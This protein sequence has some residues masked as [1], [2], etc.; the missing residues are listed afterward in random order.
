MTDKEPSPLVKMAA[1]G[2][3]TAL[4]KMAEDKGQDVRKPGFMNEVMNQPE[5]QQSGATL[6]SKSISETVNDVTDNAGT[7]VKNG[8]E[9][10]NADNKPTYQMIRENLGSPTD[11]LFRKVVNNII[12]RVIDVGSGIAGFIGAAFVN[13][14]FNPSTPVEGA[15]VHNV[16]A[17]FMS[18]AIG[19]MRGQRAA[20]AA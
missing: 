16:F 6:I 5:V 18:R 12:G 7:L 15:D 10:L 13:R 4:D 9:K 1:K 8:A 20:A 17:S 11:S 2:L 19:G 14:V 3:K